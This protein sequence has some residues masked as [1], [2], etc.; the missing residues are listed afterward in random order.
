VSWS[1]EARLCDSGPLLSIGR[2]VVVAPVDDRRVMARDLAD[3]RLRWTH[4]T[5]EGSRPFAALAGDVVVCGGAAPR[6]L[7]LDAAT[8]AIRWSFATAGRL[9]NDPVFLG[10]VVAA[11]TDPDEL[12]CLD[13]A[14]GAL[15][16]RARFAGQGY[17]LA[18]VGDELVVSQHGALS[19]HTRDA[20]LV[21]RMP[22][23]H[24][25]RWFE[26]AG[27]GDAIYASAPPQHI[28]RLR[29]MDLTEEHAVETDGMGA[30]RTL[31]RQDGVLAEAARL[32]RDTGVVRLR[33]LPSLAT[34]A[35]HPSPWDAPAPA[36]LG[37]GRWAA[38]LAATAPDRRR[39]A[40]LGP[41]GE[42]LEAHERSV[43][44]KIAGCAIAAAGGVLLAA[45]GDRIERFA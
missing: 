21:L 13:V 22:T 31:A 34:F 16:G 43:P 15:V 14:T 6:L 44:R 45:L 25:V 7:A 28:V 42:I 9:V 38:I 26:P 29:V 30:V 41:T 17:A 12:V 2:D 1:V 3:G 37:D 27:D 24:F 5:G 18:V 19:R 8:G 33:E 20:A 35:E 4:P 23:K 39:V 40:L 32:T 11:I 36:P 10:G